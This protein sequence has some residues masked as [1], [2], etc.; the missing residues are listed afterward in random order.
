MTKENTV[1]KDALMVLGLSWASGVSP[2][3]IVV[4]TPFVW[5]MTAVVGLR[6]WEY[7][8]L[9]APAATVLLPSLL[10]PQRI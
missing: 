9:S 1:A 3:A 5:P 8:E 10:F 2:S 7:G 6:A 4:A